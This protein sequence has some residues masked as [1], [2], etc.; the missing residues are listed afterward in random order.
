MLSMLTQIS[1][2]IRKFNFFFQILYNGGAE[3]QKLAIPKH[4][5]NEI[6]PTLT[7]GS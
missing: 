3:D 1:G 2:N 6:W 4:R 5:P 7:I